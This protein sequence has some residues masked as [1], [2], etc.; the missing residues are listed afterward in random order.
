M[1]HIYPVL[2]LGALVAVC[3]F[4]FIFLYELGD[5]HQITVGH[6][7]TNWRG[8]LVGL[9]LFM[10]IWIL[11]TYLND[12]ILQDFRAKIANITLTPIKPQRR[13]IFKSI[14]MQFGQFL[15]CAIV[16]AVASGFVCLIVRIFVTQNIDPSLAM[17]VIYF[18]T[19]GGAIMSLGISTESYRHYK[20]LAHFDASSLPTPSEE[21]VQLALASNT[22]A[23]VKKYREQTGLG[24][25]V[26]VDVIHKLQENGG[27]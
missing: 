11:Q 19:I 5:H 4:A 15:F 22:I 17:F 26:A 23:A 18:S 10:P 2:R 8:G 7:L 25:R 1:K 14:V 27:R 6:F 16:L 12:K 24:L 21:V 3:Y 13:S 20:Q 9:L